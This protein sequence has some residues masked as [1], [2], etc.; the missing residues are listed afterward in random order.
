[1][2]GELRRREALLAPVLESVFVGG[3]TP[4]CLPGDLFEA[5]LSMLAPRVGPGTEWTVEANPDTV[6][7]DTAHRLVSAG[8]SRVSLGAQSFHAGELEVLQRRHR[9]RAVERAVESLREAG[10]DNLSLDLI[11]GI[12]SQTARSWRESLDRL[13]ATGVGHAS[14]YLL[15]LE[16]DTP[17]GQAV[18]EGRVR[19]PDEEFQ[20]SCYDVARERLADAGLAQY[21]ISNFA[22]RGRACRH[23]L[24]YWRNRPYVGIGPSAS[25]FV[26]GRRWTNVSRVERYVALL[27]RREDP[28]AE[29]ERL[30]GRRAQAEEAML[31]L[32]LREGIDRS[33]WI[34]R[35]G[36]DVVETFSRTI[37]RYVRLGALEVTSDRICLSE[38][39]LFTSNAICAELISE[40]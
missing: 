28:Q 33:A 36:R 40:A 12:P 37:D 24:T 4:T 17:L 34:E 31:M 7:A 3:G 35:H 39:V 10:I 14:V 19:E 20:R 2:R 18:R 9:P 30:T 25:S 27:Q 15:T 6:D 1:M 23:N 21:E 11:Y 8:V 29:S 38:H 32:R 16:D 22:A 13:V 5:L 26:A